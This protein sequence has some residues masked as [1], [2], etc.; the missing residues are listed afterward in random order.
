MKKFDSP[1][2]LRIFGIC[3]DE[4]GKECFWVWSSFCGLSYIFHVITHCIFKEQL[5]EWNLHGVVI[6]S[7]NF[8]T[9]HNVGSSLLPGKEGLN[10]ASARGLVCTNVDTSSPTGPLAT[11]GVMFRCWPEQWLRF[12]AIKHYKAD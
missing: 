3:I 4:A 6:I 11:Q 12:V 7:V 5:K 9:S 2:I 10:L 8:F 1:N